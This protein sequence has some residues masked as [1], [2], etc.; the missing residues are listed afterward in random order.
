[1]LRTI[2]IVLTALIL[3]NVIFQIGFRD[4]LVY[5]LYGIDPTIID[6]GSFEAFQAA[7]TTYDARR[8]L[9]FV[10]VV[11][12]LGEFIASVAGIVRGVLRELYL[13]WIICS[14]SLV[15]CLLNV[16]AA[17]IPKRGL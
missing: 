8:I 16:F 7:K 10:G 3:A 11:V 6:D 14:I 9:L 2:I 4:T 1:M 15:L 17:I 13:N 12:N 5:Q